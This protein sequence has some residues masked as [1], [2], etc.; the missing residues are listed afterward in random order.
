MMEES[1]N[2]S[3]KIE[4]RPKE[5]FSVKFDKFHDKHYKTLLVIPLILL[6]LS[7]GYLFYF[8]QIHGDFIKKDISL[9][10]GTTITINNPNINSE[11][12]KKD[13]AS[14]LESLDTRQVYDIISNQQKAIIIETTT[15]AEE[16]KLIVEEYLGYKLDDENSS[17]EFTGST[18]SE[19]FYNQLIIALLIAFA[20]MSLVVFVIFRSFVPSA[21]V[22]FSC[23][24]DIVMALATANFL[25]MEI[26][27]A[28]IV[29]FLMLIGYSVDTDILLTNRVLKGSDSDSLNKKIFGSFKTG[30]TM[31]IIAIISVLSALLVIQSFSEVLSQIFTII[32][33]GLFFDLINTWVTNVSILKWHMINKEKK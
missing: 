15:G 2:E 27:S 18:L 12:I 25:G 29:A 11:T 26:S 9:T 30:V 13:L 32:L 22:I 4:A 6:V 10:G 33:I 20:L 8:Y 23:F 17:V 7:I 14:K 16:S 5:K 19:G 21:A 31:T 24:A 3:Q 1:K 28:G